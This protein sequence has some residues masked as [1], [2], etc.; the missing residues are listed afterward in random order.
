MLGNWAFVWRITDKEFV[1]GKVQKLHKYSLNQTNKQI[2]QRK[3]MPKDA[4]PIDGNLQ[5]TGY[6]L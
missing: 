5:R 2:V 6:N 4:K 3:R 1:F